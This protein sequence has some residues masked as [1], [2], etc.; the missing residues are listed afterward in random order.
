MTDINANS[1]SNLITISSMQL[2]TKNRALI[3]KDGAIIDLRHMEFSILKEMVTHLNEFVHREELCKSIWGS[4]SNHYN[5]QS[6]NNY[7]RRLRT[8]FEQDGKV[9][10]TLHRGLG[11]RL[12]VK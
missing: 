3:F 7:I 1:F 4:N 8:I 11:Y 10:I 12:N 9:E 5:E 2:D 6:L